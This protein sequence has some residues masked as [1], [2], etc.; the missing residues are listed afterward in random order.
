MGFDGNA[1]VYCEGY[2]N[3]TWGKTAHGLVRFTRRYNIVGVIDGRYSGRDAGEVLDGRPSGI[4]IYPD[5]ATAVADASTRGRAASHLVFGIAPDGGL[6]SSSMRADLLKAIETGLNV[7]CGMHYLL[8]EDPEFGRVARERGVKIRD[9]RKTPP[10]QKLHGFTGRIRQVRSFRLAVLGTDSSVGKR[11]TAW[12]LVEAL[13][14]EGLSAVMIGTGQTSWM[15]GAEYGVIMDA[16]INDF[17]AGEIEHAILEAWDNEKPDVMVIEG[18]GS[19]MNPIFPG[20]FEILSAGQPH[21][22]VM[23]H[24]PLREDYD[25][26]EKT[27]IHPLDIQIRAVELISEK[28]VIAVTLNHE[29]MQTDEVEEYSERIGQECGLPTVDP[30]LQDLGPV[31]REIGHLMSK[32]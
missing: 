22:V 7:D 15:Q 2:F 4:P 6:L 14:R 5:L 16:L 26:L 30:L 17:V 8:S 31:I 13:E 19:L 10:R 20:G 9:V 32:R 1:L 18:Q 29:G 24:A 28:P 12:K 25:G 27:P 3:T 23:Q 11:T 21:A